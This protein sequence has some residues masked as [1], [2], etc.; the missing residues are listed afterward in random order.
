MGFKIID[1]QGLNDHKEEMVN[2]D[3]WSEK[4]FV[5]KVYYSRFF[6]RIVLE[7]QELE[8]GSFLVKSEETK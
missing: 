2:V 7:F 1:N 8:D 6:Q 3:Y 5:G 4:P